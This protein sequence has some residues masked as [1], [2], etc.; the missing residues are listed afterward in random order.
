MKPPLKGEGDR[1]VRRKGSLTPQSAALTA[2][3]SGEPPLKG[4]GDRVSETATP[5]S[6][7]LTPNYHS[8][9]AANIHRAAV[10]FLYKHDPGYLSD[11][12]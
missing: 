8:V 3:L 7:L 1:E 10:T 6:S 9:A 4:E 5:P 2:P 12:T 11:L